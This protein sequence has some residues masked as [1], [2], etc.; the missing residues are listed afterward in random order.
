MSSALLV[1]VAVYAFN[2]KHQRTRSLPTSPVPLH[3]CRPRQELTMLDKLGAAATSIVVCVQYVTCHV[4][5]GNDQRFAERENASA[6]KPGKI[7]LQQGGRCYGKS[8]YQV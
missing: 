3:R 8:M 6:W 4:A 2:Y 5:R 7:F 1:M